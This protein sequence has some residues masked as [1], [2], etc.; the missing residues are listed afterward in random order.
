[1]PFDNKWTVTANGTQQKIY[2]A[3]G[4]FI[5]FKV[6]AGENQIKLEYWPDTWLRFLIPASIL[7]NL[8][9]LGFLIFYGVKQFRNDSLGMSH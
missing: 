4:A 7:L 6:K 8:L 9:A 3:N 1:M 2:R 5:A